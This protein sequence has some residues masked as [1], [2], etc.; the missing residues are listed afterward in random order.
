MCVRTYNMSELATAERSAV[1][2]WRRRTHPRGDPVAVI[3]VSP[4]S[5][6]RAAADRDIGRSGALPDPGA[7]RRP[8]GAATEPHVIVGCH[9]RMSLS[10][11]I[12]G[13]HCR[14]LVRLSFRPP[15]TRSLGVAPPGSEKG[16]ARFG[17]MTTVGTESGKRVARPGPTPGRIAASRTSDKSPVFTCPRAVAASCPAL[18]RRP[19]SGRRLNCK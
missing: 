11:L 9:C 17:A 18:V 12:V 15:R 8:V 19:V 1:S 6:P 14:M 7:G 5:V 4:S 13:S 16:S 10:D 3:A 2:Q